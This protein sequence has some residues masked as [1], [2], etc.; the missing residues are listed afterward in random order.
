MLN[1]HTPVTTALDP[2]HHQVY[3][4]DH[5]ITATIALAHQRHHVM[6][7]HSHHTMVPDPQHHHSHTLSPIARFLL[8]HH[9]GMKRKS[10]R[11][12]EVVICHR[13]LRLWLRDW[14]QLLRKRSRVGYTLS[15]AS[16]VNHVS[17]VRRHKSIVN[18]SHHN[19]RTAQDQAKVR[20]PRLPQ[21]VRGGFMLR[22]AMHH[23]RHRDRG[24]GFRVLMHQLLSVRLVLCRHLLR[25]MVMLRVN[26][27]SRASR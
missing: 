23:K 6:S 15:L 21:W 4:S 1:Q 18:Q 17:H 11:D 13:S 24:E 9:R 25:A 27:P 20:R 12:R 5:H 19:T 22:L 26:T 16:S 2:Q 8:L 3:T 10:L 14:T 7:M